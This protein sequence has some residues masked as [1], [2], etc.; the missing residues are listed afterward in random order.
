MEIRYFSKTSR[1]L[2][3]LIRTITIL[4][5]DSTSQ[6]SKF[7]MILAGGETPQELYQ[8]LGNR[9]R[10]QKNISFYLSDERI[11]PTPPTS[12]NFLMIESMLNL[13][14]N[15]PKYSAQSKLAQMN[16]KDAVC[17]YEELISDI[18]S[19]NLAILGI[20]EDGHT[21]SLF[22]GN[23][24]GASEDSPDV[25]PVM[26]SPKPPSTRITLSLNRINKTDHIIF[27][28]KGP[29]KMKIIHEILN[30]KDLPATKV[31]GRI[32]TSIYYLTDNQ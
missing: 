22:P 23:D 20:G 12:P 3:S 30:G 7:N 5:K 14:R 32:S 15:N 27:L 17:K 13:D 1:F 25:L 8:I 31:K 28:A 2:I 24:L 21:A 6:E 11:F 18:V 26:N 4:Y 16:V 19:F 29:S 9:L 10:N